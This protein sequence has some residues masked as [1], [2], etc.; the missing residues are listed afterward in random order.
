MD[1]LAK[2]GA[3]L[4]GSFPINWVRSVKTA[5][6]VGGAAAAQACAGPPKEKLASF[7]QNARQGVFACIRRSRVSDLALKRSFR[8]AQGRATL[9]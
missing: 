5:R 1:G 9:K 7:C 8:P 4:S 3:D 6:K 2:F